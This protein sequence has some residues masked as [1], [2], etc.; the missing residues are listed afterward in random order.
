[1]H[2]PIQANEHVICKRNIVRCILFCAV[3]DFTCIAS[4]VQLLKTVPVYIKRSSHLKASRIRKQC[5]IA[6]SAINRSQF[7]PITLRYSFSRELSF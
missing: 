3:I 1:M 4:D 7:L 6:V 5:E 2:C